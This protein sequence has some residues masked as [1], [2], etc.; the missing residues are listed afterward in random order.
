MANHNH[1]HH[2]DTSNLSLAFFL[3]LAF[4]VIEVI[5]GVLTNSV[6]I[7]ADALHDLG[8]SL[9]LG[10]AWYFQIVSKKGRDRN[11]S[12]GYRRFSLLGA[13]INSIV[14]VCG[15]IFILLETIPRV[16]KPEVANAKG[17]FLLAILG[18]IVNGVA[19]L[20]L[21]KGKSMNERVVLLHLLEDVL[22]WVAVL[23]GSII[24]YF[25]DLP[26]IDP[27]LSILIAAFILFNV[28][29]NLK[30]SFKIIL[31][32]I[33]PELDLQQLEIDLLKIP[34]VQSVHDLHAWSLDGSFNILTM[35]LVLE[36]EKNRSELF[37]LKKLIRQLLGDLGVKHLT[38]EFELEG[39][40]CE[41][42]DC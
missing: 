24:M 16:L 28:F 8:D 34:K 4:T 31:Q 21:K 12:Y 2:H 9:S 30:S 6:A 23:V 10:L 39:E 29:K 41:L 20:R 11:Y 26:I 3:N 38:L 1:H 42:S 25:F 36:S 33:P 14:L 19:V 22:G 15:S 35:H 37:A 5:G 7:L 18:I 32:G 17:M 27:I 13:L 40:Y